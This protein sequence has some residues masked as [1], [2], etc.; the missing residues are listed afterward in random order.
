VYALSL[1][2]YPRRF[3][4]EF[5]EEAQSVFTEALG[6]AADRGRLAM[7]AVCARELC[8]WPGSLLR[9]HW[10]ALTSK[11][12]TM[13]TIATKS[14]PG[15]W[16]AAILAG[17]PHFLYALALYLSSLIGTLFGIPFFWRASEWAFIVLMIAA[18]LL[19]WRRGWPR[20]SASWIGYGLVW[21]LAALVSRFYDGV[22]GVIAISVWLILVAA[23]IFI[24]ARRDQLAVLLAVLPMTPMWL[25]YLGLDGVRGVVPEAVLYIIAGLLMALAVGTVVRRGS[26]LPGVWF[27]LAV[28]LAVSLAVSYGEVYHSNVP[29][30]YAAEPTVANFLL[31]LIGMVI[32]C[33]AFTAPLWLL[34]LWRWGRRRWPGSPPE[35]KSHPATR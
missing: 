33:V 10:S 31:S 2:L 25:W 13:D 22:P 14:S 21:I 20:W 28:I 32:F 3:R 30:P 8:D 5:G 17:S 18:L 35:A 4:A 27:L 26:W 24:L 7:A 1:R 6:E 16:G 34:F 12:V 29:A 23:T 9:E 15:S 19:A 11:E